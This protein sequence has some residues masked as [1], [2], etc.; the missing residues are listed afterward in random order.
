MPSTRK[1]KG[2]KLPEHWSECQN[3]AE[4]A[5]WWDANLSRVFEEALDKGTLKM[6]TV[7]RAL[8]QAR[9]KMR[10]KRPATKLLT[11]RIPT[12]TIERAKSEAARQ[13][14]P[15]QTLMRA[16]LAKGLEQRKK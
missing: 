7:E 6:T 4:E 8:A 1:S 2:R 10:P 9:H 5:R 12:E 13:G 11:L 14:I 3:E 16:V 15:Y